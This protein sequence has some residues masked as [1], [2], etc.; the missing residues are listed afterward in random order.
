MEDVKSFVSEEDH[1]K[2]HCG[3]CGSLLHRVDK[4]YNAFCD[5]C[6]GRMVSLAKK[7]INKLWKIHEEI[8]I[9]KKLS[10]L[11]SV[12]LRSNG[13]YVDGS[14]RVYEK[15]NT[16]TAKQAFKLKDKSN[17]FVCLNDKKRYVELKSRGVIPKVEK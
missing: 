10:G 2:F 3:N 16:Y 5:G 1:Q 8:K 15:T 13:D 6:D 4:S 17:L 11:P 7:D 12:T 14:H 9:A